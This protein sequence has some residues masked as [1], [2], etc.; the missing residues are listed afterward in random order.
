MHTRSGLLLRWWRRWFPDLVNITECEE[1]RAGWAVLS[2]GV[3]NGRSFVLSVSLEPII[4]LKVVRC[5][6]QGYR[7]EQ[8]H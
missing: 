7:R 2:W 1:G 4:V 5:S 6:L 3:I 8:I